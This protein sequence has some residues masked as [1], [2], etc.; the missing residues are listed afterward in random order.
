MI[1]VTIIKEGSSTAG[2]L[3]KHLE[4]LKQHTIIL[5]VNLIV[6]VIII[7]ITVTGVQGTAQS[8]QKSVGHCC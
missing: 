6:I 3:L 5:Q 2:D 8:L 1:I 4:S 7:I